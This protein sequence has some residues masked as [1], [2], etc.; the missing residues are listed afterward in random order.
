QGVVAAGWV[1]R[2]VAGGGWSAGDPDGARD[3]PRVQRSQ[4]WRVRRARI[5]E[6]RLYGR[7]GAFRCPESDQ[8]DWPFGRAIHS[9]DRGLREDG[10]VQGRDD[11]YG[12]ADSVQGPVVPVLRDG[13][14]S[15]RGGGVG[16]ATVDSTRGDLPAF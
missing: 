3:R 14:F 11:V 13:G 1:L 4:Q 9:S 2:F 12:S 10:T 6:A 5:A 7:S 16:S 15:G 8:A